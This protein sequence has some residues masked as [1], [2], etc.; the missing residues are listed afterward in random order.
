MAAATFRLVVT[1]DYRFGFDQIS[2]A[3]GRS[4]IEISDAVGSFF[5]SSID[6]VT[7]PSDWGSLM[8]RVDR[9]GG[10]ATDTNVIAFFDDGAAPVSDRVYFF[11]IGGPRLP[12]A[13][14]PT[15]V[16]RLLEDSQFNSL[17]TTELFNSTAI[18]PSTFSSLTATTQNDVINL[19]GRVWTDG[20]IRSGLGN[21]NVTGTSANDVIDL[22]AGRDI[23][24]GGLGNDRILGVAGNDTLIGGAGND[25]LIGG[26]GNDSL[27]GGAGRDQLV[28]G[29]GADVFVFRAGYGRDTVVI[30]ED[31]IDRINLTSFG[32][33]EAQVLAAATETAGNVE[34]ALGGASVL[35]ILNTTEAALA[36]DF[37]L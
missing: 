27:D 2:E 25:T 31:G 20:P 29:A 23:G 4:V 35:V 13:G 32:L 9:P 11:E 19:A 21:D 5:S 8:T 36:G 15:A 16:I 33:T 3:P 26:G 12:T 1:D 22:G 34:I 30:F 10:Q 17:W 28:G 6:G 7:V 37:L 18:D 24:R 14:D